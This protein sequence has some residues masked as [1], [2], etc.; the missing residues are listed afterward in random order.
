MVDVDDLE[1]CRAIYLVTANVTLSLKTMDR[2]ENIEY[3]IN[4][5]MGVI[6]TIDDE[7]AM[8]E[9]KKA[10]RND[11]AKNLEELEK[12]KKETKK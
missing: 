9:I 8:R 7:D 4:R 3:L 10:V 1:G 12:Q 6:A 2:S 5:A 11:T